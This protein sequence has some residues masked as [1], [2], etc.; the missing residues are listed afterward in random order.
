MLTGMTC[1]ERL[2]EDRSNVPFPKCGSP[3][4]VAVDG[5]PSPFFDYVAGLNVLHDGGFARAADG[6]PNSDGA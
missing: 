6:P 5:L 3:D 1:D 4:S 2:A